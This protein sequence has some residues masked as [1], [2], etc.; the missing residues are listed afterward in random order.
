MFRVCKI[1]KAKDTKGKA[2]FKVKL[3]NLV[4]LTRHRE[5]QIICAKFSTLFPLEKPTFD[6]R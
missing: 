3:L 2:K 4:N 6:I 5:T 1:S